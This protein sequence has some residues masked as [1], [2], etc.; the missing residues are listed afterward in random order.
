MKKEEF[1]VHLTLVVKWCTVN[2]IQGKSVSKYYYMG[3]SITF[4]VDS[5]QSIDNSDKQ[6]MLASFICFDFIL[7]GNSS[8]RQFS[9]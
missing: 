1:E 7:T 9:S 8:L 3:D 6:T 5:C 4:Y 2:N